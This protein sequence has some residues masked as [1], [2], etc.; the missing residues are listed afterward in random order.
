MAL[1]VATAAAFAVTERLK[2]TKSALTNGTRISRSFSPVCGCERRRANIRVVLRKADTVDVTMVDAHGHQVAT[3][4]VADPLPRGAAKFHWDG[5][6]DAGARA[7]DGSY[8]VKIHFERQ[9]QTITVPNKILLDTTVPSVEDASAVPDTFSPDGD[10][11]ADHTELR[12]A[13]SKPAHAAFYLDGRRILFT[14]KHPQR[15]ETT[16]NGFAHD[17]LL[18]A[19]TYTL[20]VGGVDAAGNAT[21]VAQRVAIRV[22]IRYIVL[23]NRRLAARAG[24]PFEIG[25]STDAKRYDWQ[26]GKRK[27]VASGSVLKLRAPSAPGAYT[28]TVA[29]HGHVDRARVVVRK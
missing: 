11:Q 10:H 13:F 3:L 9:H 22:T 19:G 29:E 24:R 14:H 1:L 17:R 7:P 8:Q 6:T 12:W 25:V 26:L 27:G 2:L 16:W 4:A 18:R 21:P 28:L 15:G 23:A 20:E 5:H